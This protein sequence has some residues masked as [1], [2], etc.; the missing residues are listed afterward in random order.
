[1]KSFEYLWCQ[2]DFPITHFTQFF[3]ILLYKPLP[4]LARSWSLSSNINIT[5]SEPAYAPGAMYEL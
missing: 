4:D 3:Q 2:F 1:M 5:F